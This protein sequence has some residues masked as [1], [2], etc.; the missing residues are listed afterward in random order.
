MAAWR[1]VF[2]CK[3]CNEMMRMGFVGAGKV[4]FSLG[5]YFREKGLSVVGY[6]SRHIENAREA[7]AFTDS[8]CFD[9]PQSLAEA[10]DCLFFTVPDDAIASVWEK[11]A[12]VP[13]AG[14]TFC[15]CSASLASDIFAG[16]EERG[17]G[18]CSLHPL[19]AIPNRTHSHALLTQAA[20][21]LE[22]TEPHVARLHAMIESLGNP[23]YRMPSHVK[24]LYHCAAV[25]VSNFAVALAHTGEQL[26]RSCG[27]EDATMPLYQLMLSNVCS[28]RELGPEAAL[29][30][31]VERG[32]A[33]TVARHLAALSNLTG[34]ADHKD[35][36]LYALLAEKL[37]DI[38]SIKHPD[39]D[40]HS[41][42]AILGK[43]SSCT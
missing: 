43:F 16:A 9:S 13:I 7:A 30:G 1:T 33:V 29:T 20:F 4:G 31:P 21:F 12:D 28:V 39:R 17:A 25:F 36:R 27:M 40:Y 26:F 24:E 14:K 2:F 42:R 37:V 38:A 6:A 10:C 35:A 18:A 34:S 15:H 23:A 3:V 8:A 19:M 41:I 5:R 22:G 32:D 11:F